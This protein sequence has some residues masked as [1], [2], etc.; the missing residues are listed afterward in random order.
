MQA[1][2]Y[3]MQSFLRGVFC[4]FG[5]MPEIIVGEMYRGF[6]VLLIVARVGADKDE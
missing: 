2:V 6:L 4:K 5:L 1:I 3:V